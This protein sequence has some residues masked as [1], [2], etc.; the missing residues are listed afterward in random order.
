MFRMR[1]TLS[2]LSL[3]LPF[4]TQVVA[5]ATKADFLVDGKTLPGVSSVIGDI[6]DSYA[7]QLPISNNAS[8]PD[9]MFFWLFPPAKDAPDKDLTIWFGGG[10]GCSGLGAALQSIGPFLIPDNPNENKVIVK[11][12]PFSWTN[13]GWMMFIDQ[14][15]YTGLSE[16]AYKEYDE[17]II[18]QEFSGFLSNFYKT[19]P[20]LKTKNLYLQ[21][22]SYGGQFVPHLADYFYN[23]TG[24]AAVPLKGIGV[25]SGRYMSDL[26]QV[27]VPIY[28]YILNRQ[29]DLQVDDTLMASLTKRA[30]ELG[31]VGYLNQ[32]LT[33]PPQK[34]PIKLPS[35]YTTQNDS[36]FTMVV[37]H[38][39]EKNSCF[40][41]YNIRARCPAP[42]KP[43]TGKDNFIQ[44]TPG[45]KK[46]LHVNENATWESCVK[47]SY[48]FGKGGDPTPFSFDD[49]SFVRSIE[50]SERVVIFNGKDDFK[51]LSLGTQLGIQ[52]LT[53]GGQQGFQDPPSSPLT[54][55]NKKAGLYHTERKLTFAVLDDAGHFAPEQ[56]PEISLKLQKFLLGQIGATAL[57]Q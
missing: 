13:T 12:N 53:W 32:T 34:G 16:I 8:N 35:K 55:N 17:K 57:G 19:F 39:L 3:T 47:P 38:L 41:Y 48:I 30:E 40:D 23:Q 45:L 56:Q 37:P 51:L 26:W 15:G 28:D 36:I 25:V 5:T 52:N 21:G 6:G 24:E 14:P 29:K 49:G 9:R 11:K 20:D 18:A 1:L 2:T 50:S 33:Y 4:F 54:L 10:P 44:S 31:L 42:F 27:D 46:A 22:V 43:L 7:G